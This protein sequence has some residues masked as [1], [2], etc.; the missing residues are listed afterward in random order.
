M[1]ARARSP[2]GEGASLREDIIEA[3][4]ALLTESG[5]EQSL[6]VR[7]IAERVGVST[8]SLYLH[9]EDR[10][11]IVDAVCEQVWSQM[12]EAMEQAAADADGPMDALKRRGLAY[13]R[14]GFANPEHY[15]IVMMDRRSTTSDEHSAD[16]IMASETF[17]HL[18]GSVQVCIDEG[19][20][21]AGTDALRIGLQLWAAAHGITSLVIAKPSFPWP[22]F[23]VLAEEMMEA[24]G[25][26]LVMANVMRTT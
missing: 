22:D 23:D 26:G 4:T 15:R 10:Q 14:F 25:G 19:I 16:M 12:H 6:S 2:R 7:A 1:N 21:P 9:F 18:V 11:A 20:F 17:H 3:A 13:I 24:I 5:D 8:P